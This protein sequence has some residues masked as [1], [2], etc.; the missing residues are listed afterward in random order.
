M[1]TTLQQMGKFAVP[2]VLVAMMAGCATVSDLEKVQKQVDEVRANANSATATANEAKAIAS[3]ARNTANAAASAS[4]SAEKYSSEA[5]GFAAAAVKSS[6]AAVGTAVQAQKTV[7]DATIAF[8]WIRLDPATGRFYYQWVVWPSVGE[9]LGTA[10]APAA[11][12][13]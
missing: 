10:P 13:K 6:E 4:A 1:K 3:E 8:P 2:A 12:G 5:S 9:Y 11:N 7:N